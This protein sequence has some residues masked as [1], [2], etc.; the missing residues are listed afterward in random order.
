LPD[1]VHG[2]IGRCNVVY[3]EALLWSYMHL[4]NGSTKSY[5]HDV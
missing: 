2:W 4:L 5:I 1:I 3:E